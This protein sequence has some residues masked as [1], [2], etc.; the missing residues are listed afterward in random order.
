M[1]SIYAGDHYSTY[2]DSLTIMA[3][4]LVLA[5]IQFAAHHHVHLPVPPGG[6]TLTQ[7]L[8]ERLAE[9]IRTRLLPA[10]ARLP[11]VRECARQQG[12]SPYTVVAA[13]DLL[14]AQGLVEARPQRGFFVRDIVQNPL[15]T[16]EGKAQIAINEGRSIPR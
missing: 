9:R 4:V 6:L 13:Y 12:V 14:Q 2:T 7:Q 1:D 5:S 11:S 15:Q 16:Q 8:A 3:S 10:G